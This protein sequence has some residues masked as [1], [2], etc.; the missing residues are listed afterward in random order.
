VPWISPTTE[1]R[2][3]AAPDRKGMSP[4]SGEESDPNW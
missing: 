3:I 1:K 2:L 4:L